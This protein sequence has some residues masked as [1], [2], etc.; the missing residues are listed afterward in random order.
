VPAA[1]AADSALVGT[2]AADVADAM[3]IAAR[4][5]NHASRAGSFSISCTSAGHS[6][7]GSDHDTEN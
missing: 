7:L 5:V 3:T 2:V 1:V 6:V 4:P